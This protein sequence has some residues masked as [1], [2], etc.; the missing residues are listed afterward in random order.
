[1][2]NLAGNDKP[3]LLFFNQPWC[4]A[5]NHLKNNLKLEGAELSSLSENFKLINVAGDDN[6]SFDVS[7]FAAVSAAVVGS[8]QCTEKL[9]M[10]ACRQATLLMAGAHDH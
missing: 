10:H 7:C 8:Q 6:N 4:G 1:M 5:C 2:Q 9:W 3:I